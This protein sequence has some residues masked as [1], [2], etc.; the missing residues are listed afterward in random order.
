MMPATML[1]V[2]LL[3]GAVMESARAQSCPVNSGSCAVIAQVYTMGSSSAAGAAYWNDF[4]LVLNRCNTPTVPLSLYYASESGS[5]WNGV[6]IST[7]NARSYSLIRYAG[8]VAGS[9][10]PTPAL[11]GAVVAI[12][13]FDVAHM[14]GPM[15]LACSLGLTPLASDTIV[16]FSLGLGGNCITVSNAVWIAGSRVWTRSRKPK[17]RSQSFASLTTSC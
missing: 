17:K 12:G 15:P 14:L 16:P 9:V 4:V 13:H 3:L 2:A 11:A 10:D 5:T 8:S 1:V 6:D 7:V